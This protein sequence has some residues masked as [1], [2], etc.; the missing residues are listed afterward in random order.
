MAKIAT[1]TSLP[2]DA[3]R[4]MLLDCISVAGALLERMDDTS[5]AKTN[6]TT[7]V[8]IADAHRLLSG[9]WQEATSPPAMPDSPNKTKSIGF[10]TFGTLGPFGSS[11]A[12]GAS[13]LWVYKQ[14]LAQSNSESKRPSRKLLVC[15]DQ[16]WCQ[17]FDRS[18]SSGRCPLLHGIWDPEQTHHDQSTD[19]RKAE[20]CLANVLHLL[21]LRLPHLYP[22]HPA[23]L[24]A[25][26][27]FRHFLSVSVLD[28]Q[29]PVPS[30]PMPSI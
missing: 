23:C 12:V 28:G 11:G 3:Y 7:L 10:C 18:A 17:K 21:H 5:E 4:Q 2:E 26:C 6:V 1:P 30:R 27:P 16:V 20:P 8:P 9:V 25:P 29:V 15:P 19:I 22:F 24:N 14:P 13:D